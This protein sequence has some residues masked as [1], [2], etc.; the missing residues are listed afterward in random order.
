MPG[1]LVAPEAR[2]FDLVGLGE[3]S[4]DLVAVAPTF[5]SAGAKSRLAQFRPLAGGQ[6][7]TATVACRRLGGRSRVWGALGDDA[8]GE[9]IGRA[10]AREGVDLCPVV[11]PG[12]PS[13][14]ALILVTADTGERTI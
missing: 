10:L 14:T 5:P 3:A 1:S 7:A 13:R 2:P 6:A 12:V 9:E 8:Y 4:M 11:R